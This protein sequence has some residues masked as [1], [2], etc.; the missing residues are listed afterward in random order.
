MTWQES[1]IQAVYKQEMN[2]E[3]RTVFTNKLINQ[4]TSLLKQENNAH[5]LEF[6]GMIENC[7]E[8]GNGL[9]GLYEVVNN[10]LVNH[11]SINNYEN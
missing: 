10:K 4:I 1:I 6:L 3:H 9:N 11:Q 7:K 8:I 2:P 5:L